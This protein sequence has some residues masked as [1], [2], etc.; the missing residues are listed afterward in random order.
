MGN[1]KKYKVYA[2]INK[3]NGKAY[4]GITNCEPSIRWRNGFGY[5]QQPFFNAILKYGWNGFDHI[6]LEEGLDRKEACKKEIYYIQKYDSYQNG[7]N[8]TK[9]SLD[10]YVGKRNGVMSEEAYSLWKQRMS[11]GQIHRFEG[12]TQKIICVNDGKIYDSARLAA[13]NYKIK[14]CTLR[15]QCHNQTISNKYD[16]LTKRNYIFLHYYPEENYEYNYI[17]LKIAENPVICLETKE[18]FCSQKEACRVYNISAGVMSKACIKKYVCTKGLHFL[19]YYDYLKMTSDEIDNVMRNSG[20]TRK[21]VLVNTGEIFNSISEASQKYNVE[22]SLISTCVSNKS[23]Y[24][25]IKNYTPLIWQD[26]YEYL[27]NPKSLN[28]KTKQNMVH[29]ITTDQYFSCIKTAHIYF[30]ID[31]GGISLCC[32]GKQKTCGKDINGN[33]LEW[34]YYFPTIDKYIEVTA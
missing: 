32:K 17:L 31:F 30:Q 15:S 4:I 12:L 8:S 13:E 11:I 20:K 27:Q 1:E 16:P 5:R 28:I 21:I 29:C 2:H 6:I 23:S 34:E 9:G 7:Y 24:A 14:E 18:L 33:K 26:Y 22:F 25:G 10:A 19:L 3:S